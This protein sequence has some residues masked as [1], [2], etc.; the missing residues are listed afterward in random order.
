VVFCVFFCGS[1][2]WLPSWYPV[3]DGAIAA[4]EQQRLALAGF[5]NS[6][7]FGTC[8]EINVNNGHVDLVS[9]A[10]TKRTFMNI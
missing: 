8:M 3:R 4:A 2:T 7:P 9:E 5:L 10:V 1:S 6:G